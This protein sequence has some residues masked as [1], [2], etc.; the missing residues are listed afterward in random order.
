MSINGLIR[1]CALASL[2]AL[3]IV[4]AACD[5]SPTGP[6]VNVPYSQVD[7]TVG[8]GN[9]AANG[10]ALSVHY[11]GWLYDADAF[12]Q[13]GA[14]FDSSVGGSPYTF[15]LGSGQVIAGWDMGVP[16]MRVGGVRRLVVPPALAYGSQG[17]GPI[18]PNAT[19]VFE[20]QLL[21]VLSA[22]GGNSSH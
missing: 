21:D 4:S 10:N 13:K 3:S 18:P 2:A 5:M 19:L 15:V 17:N 11:T 12:E 9:P 8:S 20:I 1:S 22:N 14:L 7:L 6:S 16:G